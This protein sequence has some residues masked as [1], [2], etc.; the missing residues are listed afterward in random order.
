MGDHGSSWTH[1]HLH[2]SA[3]HAVLDFRSMCLTM[4]MSTVLEC[5]SRRF[6][7]HDGLSSTAHASC[8]PCMSQPAGIAPN[9]CQLTI[10]NSSPKARCVSGVLCCYLPILHGPELIS[11]RIVS[12]IDTMIWACFSLQKYNQSYPSQV[13]MLAMRVEWWLHVAE[14]L[15]LTDYGPPSE[16]DGQPIATF[17]FWQL[18][19]PLQCCT[20][21]S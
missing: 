8:M 12:I 15:A 3:I 1:A 14:V 13:C 16:L 4:I 21:L 7:A 10:C 17:N 5:C 11:T 18:C 6:I 9:C 2:I 19:W 20:I